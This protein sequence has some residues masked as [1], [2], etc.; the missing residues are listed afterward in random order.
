MAMSIDDIKKAGNTVK[1]RAFQVVTG[2]FPVRDML[3][4]RGV[5]LTPGITGEN[6]PLQR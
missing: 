4:R 3:T 6:G 5:D 1:R 2:A